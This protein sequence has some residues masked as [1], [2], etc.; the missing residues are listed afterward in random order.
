MADVHSVTHRHTSRSLPDQEPCPNANWVTEVL[1][2]LRT[3]LVYGTAGWSAKDVA[4]TN[5]QLKLEEY[6]SNLYYEISICLIH[7]VHQL[8]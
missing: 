2:T 3:R 1:T 5:E 6:V 4:L 7:K 8:S